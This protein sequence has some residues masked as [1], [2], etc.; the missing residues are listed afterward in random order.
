MPKYYPYPFK[1]TV[2]FDKLKAEWDQAQ[3]DYDDKKELL[4]KKAWK[5][6]E[7][8]QDN[9]KKARESIVWEYYTRIVKKD[10]KGFITFAFGRKT[11]FVGIDF[12]SI[13]ES[14]TFQII[15][16][17]IVPNYNYGSSYKHKGGFNHLFHLKGS[18]ITTEEELFILSGK[19]PER[20]INQSYVTGKKSESGSSQSNEKKAG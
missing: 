5:L 15:N 6:F 8:V 7:E 4:L 11:D 9:A 20:F 2:E 13:Q 18:V 12:E 10:R 19:V 16:N 14:N 17:V 1:N 3:K